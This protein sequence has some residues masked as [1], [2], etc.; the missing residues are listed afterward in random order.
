M[1]K[2]RKY[3]ILKTQNCYIVLYRSIVSIVS[4]F[5]ILGLNNWNVIGYGETMLNFI[6]S[7][8]YF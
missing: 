2:R 3:S 5:K 6:V 4:V 8:I 1:D 7:Q